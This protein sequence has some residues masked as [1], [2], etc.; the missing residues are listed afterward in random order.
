MDD[1]D[2]IRVYGQCYL[3]SFADDDDVGNGDLKVRVVFFEGDDIF[4]V[5]S[6]VVNRGGDCGSLTFFVEVFQEFVD[7]FFVVRGNV[8]WDRGFRVADVF[9]DGLCRADENC[10]PVGD[11][12]Q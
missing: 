10:I 7:G 3:F 9:D 5:A 4:G 2:D 6:C 11:T 8:Y 1:F 12:A